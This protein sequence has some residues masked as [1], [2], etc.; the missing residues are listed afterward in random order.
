[1]SVDSAGKASVM[2][3]GSASNDKCQYTQQNRRKAK[4]EM[5]TLSRIGQLYEDSAAKKSF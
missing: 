1:M 5:S 2:S 4:E 3:E